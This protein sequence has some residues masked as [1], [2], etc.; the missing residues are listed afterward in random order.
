Q[1]Q[2]HI[3]EDD[4]SLTGG[5]KGTVSDWN[6]DLSLTYGKDTV[7]LYTIDSANPG[8]FALTQ[9]ASATP[10]SGLQR[11]FY[12]GQLLNSEWTGNL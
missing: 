5:F 1:P 4:F 2:E 12:D 9:A 3:R 7:A 10:L 11:N 6:Y 8:V